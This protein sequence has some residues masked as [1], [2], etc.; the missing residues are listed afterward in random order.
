VVSIAFSLVAVVVTTLAFQGKPIA[1]GLLT[2][3]NAIVGI[4]LGAII[5]TVWD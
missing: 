1:L 5:V 2:A 4:T 3:G